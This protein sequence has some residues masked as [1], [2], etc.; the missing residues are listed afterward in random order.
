[1]LWNIYYLEIKSNHFET[2]FSIIFFLIPV[3]LHTK[4]SPEKKVLL[5]WQIYD[6][7]G[8][9]QPWKKGLDI[10]NTP[11]C[12]QNCK[13]IEENSCLWNRLRPDL[14][15]PRLRNLF[16]V[17]FCPRTSENFLFIKVFISRFFSCYFLP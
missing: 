11:G 3:W 7:N 14:I 16:L 13:C 17:T 4:K 10:K 1:M 15:F 6:K 12:I 8:W 9:L 5:K 2:Q